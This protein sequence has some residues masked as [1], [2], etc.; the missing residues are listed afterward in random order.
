MADNNAVTT[1]PDLINITGNLTGNNTTTGPVQ[2]AKVI[3][4]LTFC[5]G[6]PAIGLAIYTLKNLS[7]GSTL[8]ILSYNW[9]VFWLKCFTPEECVVWVFTQTCRHVLL[10]GLWELSKAKTSEYIFY[11]VRMNSFC[12]CPYS[13]FSLVLCLCWGLIALLLCHITQFFISGNC[14]LSTSEVV[15]LINSFFVIFQDQ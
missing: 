1:V 2:V 8:L 5:I 9:Y 15:V 3:H 14:T 12:L 10:T 6:L 7:K 13:Y 4:W 11:P